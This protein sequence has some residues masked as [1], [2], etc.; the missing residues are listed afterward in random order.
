LIPAAANDIAAMLR[1]EAGHDNQLVELVGDL[2]LNVEA[3]ELPAHP[4]PT[5][6]VYTAT[7]GTRPPKNPASSPPNSDPNSVMPKESRPPY[8]FRLA[9]R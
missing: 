1:S 2:D 5:L 3:M 9:V 7:A 8:E 6:L 4:E